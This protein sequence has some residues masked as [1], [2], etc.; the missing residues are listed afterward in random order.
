MLVWL[1]TALFK[2]N[3]KDAFAQSLLITLPL[4]A[5]SGI[6]YW[7]RGAFTFSQALPYLIPA[8]PGGILGAYLTDRMNPRILKI[9]FAL[10]VVYSGARMIFA[11]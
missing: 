4:S 11:K 6:I 9:I 1:F 8:I 2:T 7:Q 5:L 3:A 10:L